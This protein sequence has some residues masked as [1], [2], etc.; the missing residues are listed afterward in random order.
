MYA[1]EETIKSKL[2]H[3]IR[4]YDLPCDAVFIVMSSQY[5]KK[6]AANV[7]CSLT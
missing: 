4:L 3:I 1:C 2:P 6:F 7:H 5:E